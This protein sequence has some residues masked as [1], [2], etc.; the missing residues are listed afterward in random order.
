M[1][2]W[3]KWIGLLAGLGLVAGS[4][5]AEP[6]AVTVRVI[7]KDAKFVG[8]SMGGARV[9]LRD[10]DTG[11]LL[12]EGLTRGGTGDTGR[13]MRQAHRRGAALSTPGAAKFTATLELEAPRR[14]E[15]TAYGPL[16]QRQSAARVSA[17]QWV[18]PGRA[19]TGGD[20]LVLELPGFAVDVL[21]PAA[22]SRHAGAPAEL[23]VA[24]N[25]VM[26]CGCPLTPGGLWD[27]DRYRVRAWVQRDGEPVADVALE[28]AGE[29]S[30]FR[31]TVRAER[32]GVYDVAVYAY[33]PDSGNT[34][35]DR[36]S[37]IVTP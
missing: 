28:Y 36:V 25:V 11:E 35:L 14:I 7:A 18:V 34:G 5:L 8:T 31:G 21:A 26:M 1:R 9:T 29:P 12:A 17:T 32:P 2:T 15:A 23:E 33:D 3:S 19:V 13:I 16:A 30:R 4:A 37:V 27:A 24:A 20:G 6:T 22:H 10:A